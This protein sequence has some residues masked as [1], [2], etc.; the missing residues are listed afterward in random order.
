MHYY[1]FNIADW[2]LGTSHLSLEE[3]AV[4]FKLINHY[5]DTEQPIPKETQQVIR[6]L[7]LGNHEVIV[8]LILNEFFVLKDNSWHH[9]R[10]D[11]EI[12][13]YHNKA[14]TSREN[15]KKG[16]RPRKNKDLQDNPIGFIEE[17]EI[18]QE[19]ILANPSITQEKANQEPRTKNHISTPTPKKSL[20]KKKPIPENFGI[21]ESVKLWAIKNNHK[22]LDKHLENFISSCKA[23]GYVYLDWDSAFMNAVRQNWA[24]IDDKHEVDPFKGAI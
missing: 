9:V 20:P 23:N 22:N 11:K 8:G 4:Y 21:S 18:T 14:E 6:R 17:P 1:S 7:R 12:E 13:D 16:G 15:G 2:H 24:K 10:C 5:Y 3:E 19:V